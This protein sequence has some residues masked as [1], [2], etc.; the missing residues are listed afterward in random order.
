[1]QQ[2]IL[3]HILNPLSDKKADF[4]YDGA[5][6][7]NNNKIVEYGSSHKLLKKFSQAKVIDF[8]GHI[9]MPPFFDRHLANKHADFSSTK[10]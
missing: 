4:I 10:A 5:M 3:G 6:V 2:I 7:V 8:E 1:M 9:I